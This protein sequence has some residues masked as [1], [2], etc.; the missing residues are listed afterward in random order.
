MSAF[1]PTTCLACERLSDIEQIKQLKA[2][3]FRALDLKDYPLLA[4][5]VARDAVF[6]QGDQQVAG[7]DRIVEYIR[8]RGETARTVHHGHNPEIELFD[9]GPERASGTWAMS[10]YFIENPGEEL[11]RGFHGYG[12]YHETYVFEDGAW[13]IATMVL[14]RIKI[15]ALSGGLPAIY[16]RADSGR[17]VKEGT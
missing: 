6:G 11:P 4:Q 3:Y 14:T 15:D 1:A 9:D 12:H 8:Q 7:R 16:R 10:D 2:R 17:D 5:V 13:R